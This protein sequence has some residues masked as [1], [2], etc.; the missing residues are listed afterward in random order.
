MYSIYIYIYIILSTA[1]D[2]I[3]DS[4]LAVG[5]PSFTMHVALLHWQTLLL[6]RMRLRDR[7]PRHHAAHVNDD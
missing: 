2:S 4:S 5:R 6:K 3:I 1:L 7:N